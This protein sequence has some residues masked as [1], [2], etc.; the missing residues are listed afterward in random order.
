MNESLM[1]GNEQH[2]L[3][4]RAL[5]DQ[6]LSIKLEW[7]IFDSVALLSG[8]HNP[9]QSAYYWWVIILQ[10]VHK[11]ILIN[12]GSVTSVARKFIQFLSS[13]LYKHHIY[14]VQQR[15]VSVN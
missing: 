6:I 1:S 13:G 8:Q 9:G 2:F 7:A 5:V 4:F 10:L 15:A 12:K 11:G 3:I 14:Y